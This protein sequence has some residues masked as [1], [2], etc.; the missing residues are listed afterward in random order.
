MDHVDHKTNFKNRPQ[1]R[2]AGSG[3]GRRCRP[4]E[5]E[6]GWLLIAAERTCVYQAGS[7]TSLLKNRDWAKKWGIRPEW[8]ID[9]LDEVFPGVK[10][11][12]SRTSGGPNPFRDLR[13]R[14]YKMFYNGSSA[15]GVNHDPK[16]RAA[17]SSEH[18]RNKSYRNKWEGVVID[19]VRGQTPYPD[20]RDW[21][22]R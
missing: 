5:R 20:W 15:R 8:L 21:L 13:N 12:L 10:L 11:W 3:K 4:W 18:W 17:M 1:N 14:V 2:K 7:E 19:I 6:W 16:T 9:R 22:Q